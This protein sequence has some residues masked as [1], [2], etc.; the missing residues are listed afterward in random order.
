[1]SAARAAAEL[2]AVWRSGGKGGRAGRRVRVAVARRLRALR[3]L[4]F[5]APDARGADRPDADALDAPPDAL[6]RSCEGAGRATSS[7]PASTPRIASLAGWMKN[8]GD[9]GMT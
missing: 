5:L 7:A 9:V 8:R 2:G 6:P 1:M 4:D 3:A